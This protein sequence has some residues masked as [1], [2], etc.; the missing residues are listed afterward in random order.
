MADP[1]A[2]YQKRNPNFKAGFGFAEISGGADDGRSTEKIDW[3]FSGWSFVKALTDEQRAFAAKLT[4]EE[5]GY[6]NWVARLRTPNGGKYRSRM[7]IVSRHRFYS[8]KEKVS[9][10]FAVISAA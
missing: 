9:R 5:P 1:A 3:P 10:S 4:G 7:V 6:C 2:P 8:V